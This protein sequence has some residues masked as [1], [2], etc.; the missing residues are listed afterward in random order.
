MRSR[1]ATNDMSAIPSGL[2]TTRPSR[3]PAAMGVEIAAAKSPPTNL[4]PA[5]LRA[6]SG[7]TTNV[8]NGC[9]ANSS[10]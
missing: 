6:K 1:T 3:T 10:R 5:L 9:S 8:V 4:T 7:S 2:P